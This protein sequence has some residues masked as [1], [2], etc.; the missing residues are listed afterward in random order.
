[1]LRKFGKKIFASL[2]TIAMVVGMVTI[3]PVAAAVPDMPTFEDGKVYSIVST[4]T[5]KALK[6]TGISYLESGRLFFDG[7]VSNGKVVEKAAF[8]VSVQDDGNYV[9]T[10][11][12]NAVNLKCETGIEFVFNLETGTGP[13]F[14]YTIEPVEDGYKLYALGGS[15]YL[16]IN[17]DNALAKVAE[18]KLKYLH[19]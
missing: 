9:F 8:K 2:L 4:T 3:T 11:V 19:L 16:G 18:K 6:A 13:N 10:N 17:G 1:M 5:G 14:R 15:S 7:T 12:G